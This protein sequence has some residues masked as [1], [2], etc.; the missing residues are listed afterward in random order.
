MRSSSENFERFSRSSSLCPLDRVQ[1][2][3][4]AQLCVGACFN[5]KLDE[6]CVTEDDCEDEGSLAPTR[7]LV[8]VRAFGQ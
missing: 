8:Y 2:E 4:V 1:T 7:S 3:V 6:V 5:E